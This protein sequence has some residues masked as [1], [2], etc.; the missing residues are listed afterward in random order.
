MDRSRENGDALPTSAG[1]RRARAATSLAVLQWIALMRGDWGVQE[2]RNRFRVESC[3]ACGAAGCG[4]M[5]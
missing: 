2:P 3:I 5:M 4:R 1:E